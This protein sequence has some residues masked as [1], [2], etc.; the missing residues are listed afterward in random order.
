MLDMFKADP[1]TL[2]TL[3]A[4]SDIIGIIAFIIYTVKRTSKGK[5]LKKIVLA[6]VCLVAVD[7][8]MSF[9]IISSNTFYD[10]N[11]EK[12]RKLDE[13]KYYS[14]DGTAYHKTT[15]EMLRTY[16]VS[17]DE[18]QMYLAERVYIDEDGFIVYDRRKEFKKENLEY[19][20]FD[21]DGNK[22][23]AL[24]SVQW[25]KNGQIKLVQDK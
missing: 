3:F 23:Y 7:L 12:Y 11:G 18:T 13:I 14:D 16:L 22:Y 10:R 19:V 4:V 1:Y 15:D 8:V 9:F 21:T 6:T 2:I 20:Y 24:D 25:N 17:E 5:R